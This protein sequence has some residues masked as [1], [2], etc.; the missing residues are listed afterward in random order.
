MF[1]DII[2]SYATF[3]LMKEFSILLVCCQDSI[4]GKDCEKINFVAIILT[5]IHRAELYLIG[6]MSN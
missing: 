5:L 4:I 1:G 3:F 2:A 6:L